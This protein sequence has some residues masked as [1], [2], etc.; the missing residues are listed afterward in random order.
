MT[1]TA[2]VRQLPDLHRDPLDRLLIA[3]ALHEGLTI[4]SGDPLFPAYSVPV[5]WG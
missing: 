4:A 3:Q 2:L 1:H 5:V